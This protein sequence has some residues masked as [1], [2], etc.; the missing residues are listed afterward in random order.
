MHPSGKREMMVSIPQQRAN[1]LCM[2]RVEPICMRIAGEE[3]PGQA[4][5]LSVSVSLPCGAG[6]LRAGVENR[7]EAR[8]VFEHTK[9]PRPRFFCSA[10]VVC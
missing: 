6:P 4:A 8:R 5:K 7:R 3:V 1:C 2:P 9:N 10:E